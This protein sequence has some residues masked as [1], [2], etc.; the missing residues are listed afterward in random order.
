MFITQDVALPRRTFLR[1]VGAALALPLLD[2]MVPALTAHG[3][4]RRAVRPRRFG[5]VYIPNGAM[6]D[7]WTP[8]RRGHGLR[9]H[10]D[11]EAARAV[12]G[13]ADRRQQPD[14]RRAATIGDHAVGAAGG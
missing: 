2:A 7:Q 6:M 13:S 10:A 14:A 5:V 12:Q 4:D 1:G 9:V 3:A 8:H 11:P